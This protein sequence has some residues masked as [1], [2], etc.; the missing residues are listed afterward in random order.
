MTLVEF[1]LA[2]VAEVEQ[3]A[4]RATDL[5]DMEPL[6]YPDTILAECEAKRRIIE[7]WGP[8]ETYNGEELLKVLAL[9]YADHPDYRQ[10]WKP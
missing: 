5:G 10:E 8:F 9:P 3:A 2:R 6:W 7:E 1:L 4:R